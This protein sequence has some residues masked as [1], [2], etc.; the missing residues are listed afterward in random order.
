MLSFKAASSIHARS[1]D[2]KSLLNL[3]KE[4]ACFHCISKFPATSVNFF[5]DKGHAHC[6]KCNGQTVVGDTF[7]Q[8]NFA[9]RTTLEKKHMEAI[10][11]AFDVRFDFQ[12]N[13]VV[14]EYDLSE[15]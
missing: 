14:R 9:I 1:F 11:E 7:V 13:T 5:S 2:N 4:A 3:S 10:Q 8:G 6:P 15:V 12:E